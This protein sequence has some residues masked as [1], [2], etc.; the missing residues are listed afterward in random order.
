MNKSDFAADAPGIVVNDLSGNLTFIPNP[1]P[2]NF[3]L[4]R[5]TIELALQA[6]RAVGELAGIGRRLLNPDLLINPF[7]RREAVLSSRIEGTHADVE[8]L[9][10]FEVEPS[11]D[12]ATSDVQEVDNY[13]R[14]MRYGLSRL[15]MT[16]VSLQLI[17]EMHAV[18][19]GGVRGEDKQPGEFRTRQNWIGYE[20]RDIAKARYVPPSVQHMTDALNDLEGYIT[21]EDNA[22]FLIKLA[23]IHYQFEAIHPFL[24]GNGRIGR[25]L[26]TLL[27]CERGYLPSPL[28]YLSAYFEHHR[29]EYL[30]HLWSV[31]QKGAWVEWIDFFLRG[32][33]EQSRD[34]VLRAQQLQDLQREYQHRIRTLRSSITLTHLVDQLF[35]TPAVT[36]TRAATLLGVTYVSAQKNIEKLV[37]LG[38]LREVTGRQWK[39]IYLAPEVVAIITAD[40]APSELGQPSAN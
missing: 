17:R 12:L 11:D 23:L 34:A 8:Q 14:A 21:N 20:S 36:A 30:D 15:K 24:D 28:L 31:S 19:L 4:D 1:L 6:E 13:S 22:L 5:K 32:V 3:N 33:A 26:I 29:E 25:L 10:L 16:N 35:I 37:E 18:L 9:V 40:E 2:P 7:L 39:R 27:L 38:I